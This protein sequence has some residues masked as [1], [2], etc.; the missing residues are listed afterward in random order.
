MLFW[1][2]GL[3]VPENEF[4]K[5][6]AAFGKERIWGR[7]SE[8]N[9]I[10]S[11][12]G[13]L[14][15]TFKSNM[16]RYEDEPCEQVI[17][18]DIRQHMGSVRRGVR[19]IN[20]FMFEWYGLFMHLFAHGNYGWG[21][22][23]DLDQFCARVCDSVF[24]D[25]G[26]KVLHILK[27]ILTVHESQMPFY[28]TPFPFQKNR[29][30][31]RD[32][33]ALLKAKEE[34]PGLLAMTKEICAACAA[35]DDLRPWL[36]HFEKLV[37]AQRRNAIIYDMA[38]ASLRY[39]KET[40]PLRKDALLT[41]ILRLNEEDFDIAREMFFDLNPIGETGVKS[42]MFPYHEIKRLIHNIRHP[43]SPDNDIVCSGIEAL[44]WLWL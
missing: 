31:D 12:M 21:S 18:T 6:C 3:Y 2:P 40:D 10:T 1:A 27:N 13:R 42:C 5:W 28:T 25:M 33:P 32:I 44:G 29:V 17:E 34:Q 35:D 37:N 8:A 41:D 15:R 16:L 43:E 20:G 38:L 39:E 24:G 19:G 11:T 36:P 14:Y 22:V 30:E 26:G 9:S 4:D 23:M 7:D